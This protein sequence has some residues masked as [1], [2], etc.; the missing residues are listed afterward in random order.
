ME[1]KITPKGKFNL[2]I[3]EIWEYR[4]LLYI[5]T[6][7]DIK[8]KYKQAVF[9]IGWAVLQPAFMAFVFTLF[10]G[11]YIHTEK[12]GIPYSVFVLS[13]FVLWTMFSNALSTASN[14]MVQNANII[15]KVYFPRL[16]IPVS[17]VISAFVDMLFGLIILI[18]G[19]LHLN[20]AISPYA[21]V[22]WPSALLLAG[23]T[24]MGIGALLSALNVKY[25]DFRFII[26]F[27]IQALLFL[28]P[29]IYPIQNIS[30][31]FIAFLI[32]MN[33]VAASL[34]LFRSGIYGYTTNWEV[35]YYG[36]IA[37]T[38]CFAAGIVVF[39]KTESYFADLA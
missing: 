24:A 19:C 8:V 13:G 10:L 31:S 1:Y 7:R 15:K 14:S 38:A 17:A 27:M 32:Q 11:K 36:A 18:A 16:I 22:Y 26:P 12:T 30:N 35:V 4:E 2:G 33:P 9:G 6:W 21:I 3:R 5:F 34:E 23:I 37:A 39:R 25:R 28:S 20:I 29:V